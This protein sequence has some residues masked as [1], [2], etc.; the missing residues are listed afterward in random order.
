[1]IKVTLGN[2]TVRKTVIVDSS[3]TLRQALDANGIDYAHGAMML[4]GVTLQAGALDRTFAE[5]GI[6]ESCY[7]LSVQKADNA[8]A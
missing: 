1:M 8:A 7:L 4:D 5:F 3:T 2:N 6:A